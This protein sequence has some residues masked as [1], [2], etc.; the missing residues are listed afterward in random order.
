MASVKRLWKIIG[1]LRVSSM[2][3]ALRGNSCHPVRLSDF[4]HRKLH[5]GSPP[6]RWKSK[7]VGAGQEKGQA[8]TEKGSHVE[9][10]YGIRA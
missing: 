9:G 8:Y 10:W 4:K 3:E 6:G 5:E 1:E 7:E 2:C